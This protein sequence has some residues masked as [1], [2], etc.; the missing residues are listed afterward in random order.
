MRFQMEYIDNDDY[1]VIWLPE[2]FEASKIAVFKEEL[3][4]LEKTTKK[5]IVLD[6]RNTEFIDS[7]GIGTIIVLLKDLMSEKRKLCVKNPKGIV[8]ESLEMA[9]IFKFIKLLP[10]DENA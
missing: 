5:D 9:K 4:K 3:T 6:M 1:R 10:D 8:K 7:S 2:N